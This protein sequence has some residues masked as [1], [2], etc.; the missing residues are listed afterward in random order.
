M[1]ELFFGRLEKIEGKRG[2]R[3]KVKEAEMWLSGGKASH[4]AP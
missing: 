4:A 2:E 1:Q 3:M